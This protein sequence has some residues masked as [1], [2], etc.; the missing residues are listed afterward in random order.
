[1]SDGIYNRLFDGF[2][3]KFVMCWRRD[4]VRASADWAIDLTEHE[5]P[6]LIGLLEDITAVPARKQRACDIVCRD[7]VCT[8]SLP[9]DESVEGLIRTALSR[10]WSA[11][12]CRVD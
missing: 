10:R 7:N 11:C 6:S 3:G 1:M 4:A 2:R 5:I 8:W 9:G 12:L